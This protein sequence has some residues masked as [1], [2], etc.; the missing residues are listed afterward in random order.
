VSAVGGGIVD[1]LLARLVL[2]GMVLGMQLLEALGGVFG[3]IGHRWLGR[4]G[5]RGRR[6][7]SRRTQTKRVECR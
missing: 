2:I 5:A 6:R 1:A 7:R 4:I 3:H